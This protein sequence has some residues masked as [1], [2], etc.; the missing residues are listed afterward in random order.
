MLYFFKTGV[1]W[2][3]KKYPHLSNTQYKVQIVCSMYPIE[4]YILENSHF[5]TLRL[6]RHQ[7]DIYPKL[8]AEYI[9]YHYIVL[10]PNLPWPNLPGAL[11]ARVETRGLVSRCPVCHKPVD[12][13]VSVLACVIHRVYSVLACG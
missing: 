9:Q 1:S 12:E 7:I 13:G 4:M 10:G 3:P 11:F 8:L 5:P 2:I 6:C